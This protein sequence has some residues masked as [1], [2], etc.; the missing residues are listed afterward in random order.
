[1]STSNCFSG[2][3]DKIKKMLTSRQE[4][5]LDEIVSIMLKSGKKITNEAIRLF[6]S[7]QVLQ[8]THLFAKTHNLRSSQ[9]GDYCKVHKINYK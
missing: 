2:T 3:C 9:I 5:I 6:V 7:T 4:K 1:M 8:K